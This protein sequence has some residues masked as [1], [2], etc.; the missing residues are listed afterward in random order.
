MSR[1]CPAEIAL[2]GLGCRFAGALDVSTYFENILAAKD[3]TREVPAERWGPETFCDPRS[4]SGDRVPTCRG[5]YLDSPLT[6]DAAEHGIMPRTVA[7]GEPEQFLVL[8]AAT[9][10]L[11]D[12]GLIPANLIGGRVEVVI[13]RGNYFNHGNL[14]RLH[15]GRMIAQTVSLLAALH[16]EWSAEERQ[17]IADDLRASLPPFEAATIPG[18]LTNATAGRLAHRFD[19]SGASF[20]VDAASASSLVAVDLAIRALKSRRAD[21]AIAGGVYLEADVDF[22]L[23]FRQLNALSRSGTSRPFGALADGMLPGEGAGVVILKRLRDAERDGD[24]IYA[25]VQGVGISSDGR[26]QGLAAPSARGHARALRRAY[27]L[28]GIDPATVA[29]V[30]GHGLGVPAADLAELKALSAVFPKPRHG[31]RYLGAVS[32][33]IGHAMPAAGIAGFIKTALALFHRVLPP[34]LSSEKPHALLDRPDRPFKLNRQVRPWIHADPGSPRRAGVNA[35]G[36]AGINAHAVLEE[37][38]SSEGVEGPGALRTWDSEAILLSAPDRAG[39]LARVRELI[40]WLKPPRLASLKDVA[41]TLSSAQ[42]HPIGAARLGIVAA[43]LSDL[44]DRLRG[45]SSKLCDPACRTIRD[46]RGVYFWHE[47]LYPPG[48]KGLAFLFPGEGSQYPGML[49]D[50][51][52]HFPVVRRYFDIADRIA[53]DVGDV[54]PP[55]THLFAPAEERDEKLWSPATAVNVVLNAQWAM[56]QLLARLDLR[57]DAVVGH[58]SGELLALAAASIFPADRALEQKLGRLGSIFRG[59]ESSGDLPEARLVAVATDRQRIEAIC[60]AVGARDAAVAMDNCPHQVV[61]AVS[62]AEFEQVVARL[63]EESILFD[64]LPFSR[65]YHTRSFA[66]VVGPIADFYEGMTFNRQTVPIYSCA[67]RRRMPD[68]LTLVRELA[69]EQWTKTVDFRETIEAMHADGLRLFVDVGARGNLTGFVEDILRGKRA[70]AIAANLPRRSGLTQLNHLVAAIFAQGVPLKTDYLYARRR[71][72]AIDWNAPEPPVRATVPLAI[73]FPRMQL[74]DAMVA[75]LRSA[76]ETAPAPEHED[77]PRSE[78]PR[79]APELR[80]DFEG[81]SRNGSSPDSQEDSFLAAT[82]SSSQPRLSSHEEIV[83]ESGHRALSWNYLE[84]FAETE[85]DQPSLASG[86]LLSFQQTMQA[87]LQTQQEIM[88]AYLEGQGPAQTETPPAGF[89]RLV[90]RAT[91]PP[92]SRFCVCSGPD[93]GPWCGE[94][95]RLLPGR[96]LEALVILEAHDDP[97]A[98]EHTLG[99]RKVSAIDP[100][101]KGLPVLP[102]AVMAEMTAQA[103]ALAVTPGLVLTGLTQVRAHKWVRYEDEPVYLELQGRHAPSN[104]D[105][106]FWVGIFNRGPLGKSE[107][108]RPVFEAIAIFDVATPSSPPAAVWSLPNSRPSKFTAFSVYDEQWLFHGPLLRAV[109]RVGRLAKEGIEGSIRVLPRA[110]LVKNGQRPLFHT[111]FIVVDNFT[112]LLGAWGLDYL[113]EGDVVF[114]LSMDELE[115]FG[116]RPPEGTDVVCRITVTEIE[117]HRL[118]AESEIIRPDGSVWMRIRDWEDWRFHWPGRY[119]DV[120]RQPR[121]F[122]LGEELELSGFGNGPV[123]VARAIWLE[124]PADMGRPVWRD[125]LEQIMFGPAERA[126]VL[127][128]VNNERQRNHKLWGRIA[129]KEAARRLWQAGGKPPV[130]PADLSIVPDQNG[131]PELFSLAAPSDFPVAAVSIAHCDGVA[132]AIAALGPATRVGIDVET[133]V[134]RPEGFEATAFSTAEQLLL[135]N[136]SGSSRLEWITRFWCAKEAAAKVGGLAASDCPLDCEITQ[137]DLATGVMRVKLGP[138]LNAARPEPMVG[139]LCVVTARRGDYAWAWALIEG[140]DS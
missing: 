78:G 104:G 109:S 7:G 53:R 51:C 75:R 1:G 57:P 88:T 6:F 118:R 113:S 125:V 82:I 19:L 115:I 119:R 97:I 92:P 14:T 8:E 27:R 124:P 15:H 95:L 98:L 112:H 69:V 4:S 132:V 89:E 122:W 61:L 32:S 2:I 33:M 111:D 22:P 17:V 139:P 13:G 137:V 133:I 107:A 18:Q 20:V 74:S 80:S 128:S 26:S 93:P 83:P 73:G 60:R 21:L 126:A 28:S 23:V 9:A 116:E 47:P 29:L 86:A 127:S 129:A 70:F 105:E 100:E 94:V 46:A 56:Y 63:R 12:A 106:R 120:M 91:A 38:T 52:I 130:Y 41:Y 102:F 11:A 66:P 34:T 99:G 72:R 68:D 5:G 117:H 71:P 39:L 44:S 30:E 135:N 81:P 90:S 54:I 84:E 96:E 77:E 134:E 101:L 35:F 140:A 16:P 79:S 123:E 85:I 42:Q 87:F 24:R 25:L 3:C 62:A 76:S 43:T 110:P 10:A 103:A 40:D 58:S 36:F 49:A 50:L 136:W 67:S 45:V 31:H 37:Y 138:A 59:F 48:A 131:R 65:A 108:L 114:P 121:D 55:S 64:V